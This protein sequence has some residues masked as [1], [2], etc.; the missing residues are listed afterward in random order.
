MYK[1]LRFRGSC[2]LPQ[3]PEFGKWTI[4]SANSARYS[5]GMSVD[6]GTTLSV[7]CQNRYKLDGQKA[8]FCD[9]GKWSSD[10]RRCLSNYNN[11]KFILIYM[12]SLQ[13]CVNLE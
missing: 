7:E 8:V 4:V 3:Y 2:V 6:P 13:K 12:I 5:P 1:W 11:S 10:I 9:N